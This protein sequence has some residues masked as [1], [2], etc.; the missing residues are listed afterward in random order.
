MTMPADPSVFNKAPR[1]VTPTQLGQQGTAPTPAP[2]PTPAPVTPAPTNLG[3]ASPPPP[4]PPP[5]APSA[6]NPVTP[7]QIAGQGPPAINPTAVTPKPFD[8]N[9]PSTYTVRHNA[10]G[11]TDY[12]DLNGVIQQ[13]GNPPT[14]APGSNGGGTAGGTA[15]N[16]PSNLAYGLF[17]LSGNTNPTPP[18]Q[19]GPP[20]PEEQAD[21]DAYKKE[22]ADAENAYFAANS[23]YPDAAGIQGIISTAAAHHPQAIA[24]ANSNNF[25][26]GSVSGANNQNLINRISTQTPGDI[27]RISEGGALGQN[28]LNAAAD[29]ATNTGNAI[30]NTATTQANSALARG[31]AG[32]ATAKSTGLGAVA[33]GEAAAQPLY[34]VGALD[35]ANGSDARN[36][37]ASYAAATGVSLDEATQAIQRL[38]ALSNSGDVASTQKLASFM[39]NN[40]TANQLGEFNPTATRT[41]GFTGSAG[42]ATTLEGVN[43]NAA[44]TGQ[45]GAF[46]APTATAPQ[47]SDL[48]TTLNSTNRAANFNAAPGE[49]TTLA[50]TL[51]TNADETAALGRFTGTNGTADALAGVNTG[52][53]ATGNLL[54]FQGNGGTAT[55][56]RNVNTAVPGT[57][58]LDTYTGAIGTAG[59]I[60]A[61]QLQRLDRIA[62]G[63]DIG[64]SA[65]EE[66]LKKGADQNMSQAIA[67]ARSG[68]GAGASAAGLRQAQFQNAA[69]EQG[70][71]TD[72]AALRAQEAA[73]AR[74]QNLTAA[75][76]AAGTATTLGGQK[77]QGLTTVQQ[78]QQQAVQDKI[79]ALVSAGGMT[80]KQADQVLSALTSAQQ[81]Q[82]QS[83]DQTIQALVA[84]GQMTQAQSAQV[85]DA[86]KATQQGQAQAIA[87]K[88]ANTI[89]AGQ[90]EQTASQ[91]QLDA[92]KVAQAGE[93][94]SVTNKLNALVA[95]GQMTQAAASQQLDALKAKQQGELTSISQTSTNVATAGQ[96]RQ[97][98]AQQQLSALQSQQQADLSA[99]SQRLQ[100]LVSAGQMTQEQANQ[101]LTAI[102]SAQDGQLAMQNVRVTAANAAAGAANTSGG[103]QADLAKSFATIGL[104]YDVNSG[105]VY[106]NGGQLIMS[107]EQVNSNLVQSGLSNQAAQGANAANIT[108]QGV[109]ALT[110]LTNTSVDA[111]KAA[112]TLGFQ[113]S[114]AIA[115]LSQAELSQLQ[116]IIQNQDALALQKYA[117]DKNIAL[118]VDAQNAQQTGAIFSALGTIVAGAALLSDV[119]AKTD[120]A[121]AGAGDWLQLNGMNLPSAGTPSDI[122]MVG[123][124]MLPQLNQVPSAAPAAGMS[125]ANK[126][127]FM[128]LAGQFGGSLGRAIGSD[129]K[130]KKDKHSE[131]FD[132]FLANRKT[133]TDFRAAKGYTYKYKDP[134]MAG[135][136]P[137]TQ[138]GPM[139]QS[140]QHTAAR[141]AVFMGPDKLLKVDPT[142]V[143]MPLMAAAGEQQRRLD[144]DEDVIAELVKMMREFKGAA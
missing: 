87:Q 33:L 110:N 34:G 74:G 83:I 99:S 41:A 106:N 107:A 49:A 3:S 136:A 30:N 91:Q 114:A 15:G 19:P 115:S 59:G 139:A 85:L 72:M 40:G 108:S 98:Q 27:A 138:Y 28:A 18:R 32:L 22:I 52:K 58:A 7:G 81:G 141:D 92:L 24:Y 84:S 45:L 105:N 48:N 111:Q 4:A 140:L 143:V 68:R 144:R 10:D 100:A 109:Q 131:T 126:L 63:A 70:L 122:G 67:L 112:A 102:K 71:S 113:T 35:L 20:T 51:N 133:D 55:D 93:M 17:D 11:S 142:R 54:G 6:P 135:A 14:G 82:G 97:V 88:S 66:L 53:S 56:L 13:H 128:G 79:G 129:E 77:L 95:S 118:Q 44:A 9:D 75:Q 89:A 78:G 43:T 123:G 61:D 12:I 46:N 90:Q 137:G 16:N 38:Q 121:P 23:R 5:P 132:D 124:N 76:A 29:Q 96:Q 39:G 120:I 64:P 116:G 101:Q 65:A 26:P 103:V 42:D 94:S 69:T 31:D 37:A 60:G 127:A 1:T 36:T 25:D 104:N 119:R 62:S 50:R 117:L 8:P 134:K 86:M 57:G 21:V 2:T 125:D 47:L 130:G 73:T 80:Q